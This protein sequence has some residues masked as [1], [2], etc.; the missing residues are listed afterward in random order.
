MKKA[1]LYGGVLIGLYILV[2]N[3]TGTGTLITGTTTGATGVITAL[4]GR[5]QG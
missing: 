3:Q 1:L 2:A 5:G 4:Q